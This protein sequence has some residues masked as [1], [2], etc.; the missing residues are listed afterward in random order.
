VRIEDSFLLT[1]GGLLNLSQKVPRTVEDI[2]R[3]MQQ[4]SPSTVNR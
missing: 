4:R 1:E 2:E 3:I